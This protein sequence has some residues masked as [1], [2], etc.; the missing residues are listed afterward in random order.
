MEVKKQYTVKLDEPSRTGLQQLV[1]ETLK[2]Y[3]TTGDVLSVEV[4]VERMITHLIVRGAQVELSALL[5]TE[6]ARPLPNPVPKKARPVKHRKKRSKAGFKVKPDPELREA[7]AQDDASLIPDDEKNQ[8]ML[9][10]RKRLGTEG[11]RMSTGQVAKLCG[12]SEASW[13][14]YENQLVCPLHSTCPALTPIAALIRT[15]LRRK[16]SEI[17]PEWAG[18]ELHLNWVENGRWKMPLTDEQKKKSKAMSN[19]RSKAKREAAE[20]ANESA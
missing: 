4:N 2:K 10:R 20:T 8:L 7:Q 9:N 17:W 15:F 3:E 5:K 13:I 18:T 12:V 11:K 1:D 19:A 14:K 16:F 6:G